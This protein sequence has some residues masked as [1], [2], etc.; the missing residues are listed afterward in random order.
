MS[1]KSKTNL[2]GLLSCSLI[3]LGLTT[4]SAAA[5]PVIT[6]GFNTNQTLPAGAIV[7]IKKGTSDSVLLAN[8]SNNNSLVGVVID[9]NTSQV[10]LSYGASQVQVATSG[11]N[12]V[13]VSDINGA[14]LP[15]QEITA[16]PINGVGM[17]ATANSEVIGTAQ[18]S[19]PNNSAGKQNVVTSTGQ[20]QTVHVGNIPVLVSIGYYAQQPAKTLI[21]NALQNLANALAGKQVKS[22]PIILS[23]LI[24]LISLFVVV[25]IIF[26]MVHGSIISVGRNPMSQAAVYRNVIQLSSLVIGI[27][28][29]AVFAIFMILTRLG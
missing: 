27:L 19:F 5:E 25:S 28:A 3:V 22:L 9:N 16:S 4:L 14:L 10:A 1:G 26:S 6:Q 23:T 12:Q 2:F 20:K 15:G 11:V 17:L 29:V 7:S 18:A 13:L 24:F 21:P 8:L